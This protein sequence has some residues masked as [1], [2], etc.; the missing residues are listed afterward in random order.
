MFHVINN[1]CHRKIAL[2]IR[3]HAACDISV[4]DFGKRPIGQSLYF[5]MSIFKV[6]SETDPTL[7][8]FLFHLSSFLMH[9]RA[10]REKALNPRIS[11]LVLHTILNDLLVNF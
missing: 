8:I 1:L 4:D 9:W 2:K 5:R 7:C 6:K 10:I 11:L 3:N